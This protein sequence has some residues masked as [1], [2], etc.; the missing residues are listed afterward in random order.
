M[1]VAWLHITNACNLRCSYCYLNKTNQSMSEATGRAAIDAVMRSASANGYRKIALKYAGGE[2]ALQ[3]PLVELI[4]TYAAEQAA[5]QGYQF[6][7]GLLS[8]GTS[9]TS[10][11]LD[12][13]AGLAYS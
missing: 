7:A 4:H 2:A 8:N 12:R 6:Q 5:A 1:L 11:K 9:L 3:M 13:C 10:R